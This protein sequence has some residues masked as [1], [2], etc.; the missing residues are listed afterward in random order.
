MAQNRK[1]FENIEAQP[2]I[3][4][5]IEQM[6]I[7]KHFYMFILFSYVYILYYMLDIYSKYI[8]KYQTNI[9]AQ[10]KARYP[11]KECA[12]WQQPFWHF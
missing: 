4:S 3:R 5:N 6:F 7:S 10:R 9:E 12:C 2:A 11:Y 1:K 8:Y